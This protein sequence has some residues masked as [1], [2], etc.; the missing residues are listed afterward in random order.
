MGAAEKQIPQPSIAGALLE[1]LQHRRHRVAPGTHLGAVG[2]LRR[3]DKLV[4]EGLDALLQRDRAL[5]VLEVHCFSCCVGNDAE[6][7]LTAG[8]RSGWQRGLRFD[9]DQHPVRRHLLAG[10]HVQRD[11]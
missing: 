3:H 8:E 6:R 11:H 2:R 9:L 10:C 1:R 5:T 4:H 7:I